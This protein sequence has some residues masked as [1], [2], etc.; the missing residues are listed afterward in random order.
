VIV[1][2]CKKKPTKR[3]VHLNLVLFRK[4]TQRQLVGLFNMFFV[5]VDYILI[6]KKR[7]EKFRKEAKN[8]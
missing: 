8:Y 5:V 7:L 3:N 1:L 6:F 2:M 4:K